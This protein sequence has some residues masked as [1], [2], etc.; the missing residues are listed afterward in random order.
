MLS[1]PPCSELMYGDRLWAYNTYY[2]GTVK[3]N[4]YGALRSHSRAVMLWPGE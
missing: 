3:A 1:A 4:D 2:M